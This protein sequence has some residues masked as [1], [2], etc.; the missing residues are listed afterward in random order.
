MQDEF[1]C[2]VDTNLAR[3]G[4]NSAQI[5]LKTMIIIVYSKRFLLIIFCV[6]IPLL[7]QSQVNYSPN[8]VNTSAKSGFHIDNFQ[9]YEAFLSMPKVKLKEGSA[10]IVVLNGS[11]DQKISWI[12]NKLNIDKGFKVEIDFSYKIGDPKEIAGP[13][14]DEGQ[15]H[16]DE[17]KG[18]NIILKNK[19]IVN[20]SFGIYKDANDSKCKIEFGIN[21]FIDLPTNIIDGKRHTI[22]IIFKKTGNKTEFIPSVILDKFPEIKSPSSVRIFAYTNDMPTGYYYISPSISLAA[23]GWYDELAL[24]AWNFECQSPG[25]LISDAI[26]NNFSS[27]ITINGLKHIANSYLTDVHD[28]AGHVFSQKFQN[29]FDFSRALDVNYLS[30][31]CSISFSI[32]ADITDGKYPMEGV[33]DRRQSVAASLTVNN[34]ESNNDTKVDVLEYGHSI[35][36]PQTVNVT[37]LTRYDGTKGKLFEFSDVPIESGNPGP[38]VVKHHV[39]GR[40]FVWERQ[41]TATR[42]TVGPIVEGL[43]NRYKQ[44]ALDNLASYNPPNEPANLA[45][46]CSYAKMY[47]SNQKLFKWAGLAA[48]VSGRV[49]E[50]SESILAK[51]SEIAG[52]DLNKT[53]L[54]GNEKVYLDLYWQH[55]LAREEGLKGIKKA[56]D[57][58]EITNQSYEGWVKILSSKS[59][60]DIWD[61]NKKLLYYEQSQILQPLMYDTYPVAWGLIT[62]AYISRKIY[63]TTPVPPGKEILFKGKIYPTIHPRSV[64]NLKDRWE[65][66]ESEILPSWRKFE[67]NPA[68]K[69][70]LIN[71]YKTVCPNLN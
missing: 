49:G 63:L 69:A 42:P 47:L 55:L 15:F 16:L 71:S 65:L 51:M 44:L 21:S 57:E 38:L 7:G 33:R 62:N 25:T 41:P 17:T 50:E 45:K 30:P 5:K 46:T 56:H 12:E 28:D 8:D 10:T 48:L 32:D 40:F 61:G 18:L 59:E 3:N 4:Y 26:L 19:G 37:S 54:D 36:S 1:G 13:N 67:S 53:V 27:F 70:L 6:M 35:N 20:Y 64:G 31:I 60:D 58:N 11:A 68:N 29:S 34:I 2:R 52:F 39:S 23:E 9:K 43:A 24:Y 22:A 14:V 66:I